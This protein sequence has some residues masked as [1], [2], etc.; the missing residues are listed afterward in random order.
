MD[1]AR[2]DRDDHDDQ[3]EYATHSEDMP[4]GDMPLVP[5]ACCLRGLIVCLR[6]LQFRSDPPKPLTHTPTFYRDQLQYNMWL[7]WRVLYAGQI[8][9]AEVVT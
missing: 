8:A 6:S 7:L 4:F 2:V 1:D 5:V 9:P 3:S